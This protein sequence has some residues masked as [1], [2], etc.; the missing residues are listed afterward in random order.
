MQ[1]QGSDKDRTWGTCLVGF[2]GCSPI[3]ACGGGDQGSEAEGLTHGLSEAWTQASTPTL[4]LAQASRVW[5]SFLCATAK[6]F[7]G[8]LG[9]PPAGQPPS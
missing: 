8:T 5:P 6:D 3:P 2:H 7:T 1:A 4:V 9:P